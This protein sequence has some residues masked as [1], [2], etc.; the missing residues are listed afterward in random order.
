MHAAADWT[1]SSSLLAAGEGTLWTFL[2]SSLIPHLLCESALKT[3]LCKKLLCSTS[4]NPRCTAAHVLLPGTERFI[5]PAQRMS[6]NVR[7]S[8]R[9][10]A[11]LYS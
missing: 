4:I 3:G 8:S 2:G 6:S 1:F 10:H 9:V 5:F 7:T 11:M